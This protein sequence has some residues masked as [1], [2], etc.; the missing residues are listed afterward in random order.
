MTNFEKGQKVV[1]K[2]RVWAV[3]DPKYFV[4]FQDL[5]A[6]IFHVVLQ[7]GKEVIETLPSYVRLATEDDLAIE[8]SIK[9][10]PVDDECRWL[11]GVLR[12][13]EPHKVRCEHGA[14]CK[15]CATLINENDLVTRY[16]DKLLNKGGYPIKSYKDSGEHYYQLSVGE[17]PFGAE[18]ESC[19]K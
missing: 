15:V 14:R 11:L 17:V 5:G 19:K 16:K 2:E 7:R 8:R 4:T 3:V 13:G 18:W 10:V 1:H 12:D 6:G 9:G